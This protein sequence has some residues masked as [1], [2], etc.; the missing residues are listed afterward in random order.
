MYKIL[1]I[2]VLVYIIY[3]FFKINKVFEKFAVPTSD[4]RPFVN[5][6]DDKGNQINVVLLSHPFTRDTTWKQYEDCKEKTN[7]SFLVYQATMNSH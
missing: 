4:E 5:V 6:Y 3:L 7:L 1:L 2:L